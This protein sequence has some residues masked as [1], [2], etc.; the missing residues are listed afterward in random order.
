[1]INL[2]K[3]QEALLVKIKELIVKYNTEAIKDEFTVE[4]YL[5]RLDHYHIKLQ[6]HHT[7]IL[8]CF[9]VNSNHDYF[10]NNFLQQATNTHEKVRTFFLK[11]LSSFNGQ[12]AL[13][14]SIKPTRSGTLL[15][16]QL[17]RSRNKNKTGALCRKN[18]SISA[19]PSNELDFRGRESVVADNYLCSNCFGKHLATNCSSFQRCER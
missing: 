5:E 4:A 3:E 14:Y 6:E 12:Y 16:T 13:N 7:R 17:S 15:F 11:L 10:I 8:D 9:N 19:C 2:Y 1:M 18:H